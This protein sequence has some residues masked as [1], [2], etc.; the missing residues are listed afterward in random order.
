MAIPAQFIDELVARCDIVD[1]VSDYV[2]LTPKGGSYWGL[3]P[4]HAEK[5]PSFHVVPDRQSCHCFG[6]GKGGGA[7]SFVMEI[8]HVPFVEAIRILAKKAGMEFPEED[9]NNQYRK[10]MDHL[11]ALSKETARYFHRKLYEPQGKGALTYL[12]KRGLSKHTITRFGLGYAPDGWDNL[13][14]EMGQHGYA[15]QDLLDA[16]LAVSGQK[17]RIYDRF[18]GR[19]MFPIIDL[20]G[21]VI[22][23]GG[24]VMGEGEPKYLNSPDSVIFNKS[25]NLFAMNF[26]KSSKLGRVILTE[27]YMDT[28]ALHQA[29]FDCAVASLGTAFTPHHARLLSRFTKEVVIAYDSDQAGVSAA[30]RAIPFLE[31]A[32]LKVKVLQMQG[33]KDPDEYIKAYGRDSFAQLLDRSEDHIEYSLSKIQ[34]KYRLDEDTQKIEFAREAAEM[35][36]SL[37][38]PVE[39]EV[40]A[41][42]VSA[43][44]GINKD[45][46]LQEVSRAFKRKLSQM[47]KKQERQQWLPAQ[48]AQPKSRELKYDNL[49][50]ARAEEGILRLLIM[51]ETLFREAG[52]LSETVFSSPILGKIFSIL[53]ERKDSG[54]SIQ[55]GA[56]ADEL[57]SEEMAHMASVMEKPEV[58]TNAKQAMA[59]YI[60]IIE[61]ENLTKAGESNEQ[62]LLAAREQYQK[63]KSMGDVK[64]G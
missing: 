18:R 47:K 27:G 37:P 12:E 11:F 10:R 1:V 53:C 54:R 31:K 20:R 19:V 46:V 41:G 13:L 29:G 44:S 8:E 25:Q 15:K 3:C 28:I 38:S 14:L 61:R 32:G 55:L 7:I 62:L 45:A 39:R 51:D 26:A 63:T 40:Y 24:R 57:T 35:I 23:F 43:L 50:S 9:G 49:R 34:Q 5:T 17:G 58:R 16:G 64:N 42:R 59:D 21:N 2:S 33:A 56:L 48:Q 30:Q 6:C 52:A 22:G 4:F 60:A 36:A